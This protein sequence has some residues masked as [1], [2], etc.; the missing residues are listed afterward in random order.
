MHDNIIQ[1][2]GLANQNMQLLVDTFIGKQ[3]GFM[4]L[5]MWKKNEGLHLPLLLCLGAIV[6]MENLVYH[7]IVSLSHSHNRSF[8]STH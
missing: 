8:F 7:K 4:N 5:K 3:H 2:H 1:V 6:N